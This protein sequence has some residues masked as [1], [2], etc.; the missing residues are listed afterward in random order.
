MDQLFIFYNE[1]NMSNTVYIKYTL[2]LIYWQDLQ[3]KTYFGMSNWAMPQFEGALSA[4]LLNEMEK[5]EK[6][7]YLWGCYLSQ[8]DIK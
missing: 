4:Q 3:L 5:D 2:I 1:G 6:S 7:S 8:F